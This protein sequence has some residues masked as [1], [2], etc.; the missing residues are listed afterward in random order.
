M[1][2]SANQFDSERSELTFLSGANEI[3][4]ALELAATNDFIWRRVDRK[5]RD[6][7]I[8]RGLDCEEAKA[9]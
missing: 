5:P 2:C 8:V 6:A 3:Q 7:R 1:E 4:G 9:N